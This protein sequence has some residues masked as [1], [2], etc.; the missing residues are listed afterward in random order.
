MTKKK[1]IG[2]NVWRYENPI[3]LELRIL[4]K[5]ETFVYVKAP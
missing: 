4:Y 5:N 1:Q 2:K 3:R